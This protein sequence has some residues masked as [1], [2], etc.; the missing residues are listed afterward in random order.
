MH[1]EPTSRCTLSCPACPRTWFS[2]TFKKP[3]PKQDLDLDQLSRFLDCESGSKVESFFLNGNHGDPIYYPALFDLILRFRDRSF[4]ISTN[5]SHQRAEFWQR[6]AQN[7]T[8]DDTVYFSIDGL[9]HN[10]HLYRKNSDWKSI[11]QG[12]DIMVKSPA[13]IIWKTLIFSYNQTEIESIKSFAESKGALFVSETTSRWGDQSLKPT[14]NVIDTS[15]LYERI[16]STT[17]IDPQCE[18]Q[19][20]ISADGYYWPCCLITS[21]YTL[22]RTPLWKDRSRWTIKDQ[23]LDQARLNLK[24]WKQGILN[25]PDHALDLCK[26]HCKPGQKFTWATM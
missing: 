2:S 21:M 9:E 4:R 14:E 23:N 26:M 19:E 16:Q 10:N 13:R 20:Y 5:G 12:L 8:K 6:L 1:I 24:Q 3:F 18:S 11:M 17:I 7:L 15:R 22:H 25:D